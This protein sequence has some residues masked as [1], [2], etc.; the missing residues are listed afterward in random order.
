VESD[1][2]NEVMDLIRDA[3]VSGDLSNVEDD[4]TGIKL[5]DAE[6]FAYTDPV[7]GSQTSNQGLIL[8]FQ[9]PNGNPAR[10]VFRLSGTGS[11]GATVRMY[12]ERFEGDASKHDETAPVA[13]KSLADRALQLV[14]MKELTGRDAPTV[15]T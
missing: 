14:N 10:V 3:F 11:A 6:E 7:D 2:A 9:Y 8:Q 5:V 1:S 13:L 4:D 12:L 15:I